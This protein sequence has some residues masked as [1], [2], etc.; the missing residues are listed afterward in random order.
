M[1]ENYYICQQTNMLAGCCTQKSN[2]NYIMKDRKNVWII[3][4]VLLI[5]IFGCWLLFS[6]DVRKMVQKEGVE[7]IDDMTIEN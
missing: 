6:Q 5:V 7:V 2:K 1:P 4:F 3:I